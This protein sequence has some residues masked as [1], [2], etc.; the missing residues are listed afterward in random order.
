MAAEWGASIQ[1]KD[2][3]RLVSNSG[4]QFQ[5]QPRSA[6]RPA[7]LLGEHTQE[8]LRQLGYDVQQI[9]GLVRHGVVVAAHMQ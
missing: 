1:I 8:I 3:A 5:H 6:S 9:A 4:V 7:P 2:L